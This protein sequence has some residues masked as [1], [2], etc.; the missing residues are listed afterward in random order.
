MEKRTPGHIMDL[1]LEANADENWVQE[2]LMIT[3]NQDPTAARDILSPI[4]PEGKENRKQKLTP[5]LQKCI[6][7]IQIPR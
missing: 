6:P 5:K 3:G 7:Q 2:T 1:P 4:Y